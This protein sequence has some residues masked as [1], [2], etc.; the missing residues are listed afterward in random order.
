MKDIRNILVEV[1]ENAK[2]TAKGARALLECGWN[3]RDPAKSM[4]KQPEEVINFLE[5][6]ADDVELYS[7]MH[8]N[9][10]RLFKTIIDA[11]GRALR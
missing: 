9:R 4:T 8:V 5:C 3:Y 7:E 6:V 2:V 1:L 11:Y 10:R